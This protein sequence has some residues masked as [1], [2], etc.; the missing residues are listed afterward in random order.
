LNTI[1]GITQGTPIRIELKTGSVNAI[2][3][4][5]L[6]LSAVSPLLSLCATN[7]LHKSER[8]YVFLLVT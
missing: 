4:C 5:I 6:F 2:V 8:L 7:G 3:T 1:L